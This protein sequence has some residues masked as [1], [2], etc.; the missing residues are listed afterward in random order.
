MSRTSATVHI[1]ATELPSASGH[2][3]AV[4]LVAPAPATTHSKPKP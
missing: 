2:I 4:M 3:E 1:T